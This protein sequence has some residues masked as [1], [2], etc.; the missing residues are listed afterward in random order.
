MQI[1]TAANMGFTEEN[2]RHGSPAAGPQHHGF[3]GSRI[4]IDGDLREIE[5][6]RMQQRLGA[7]AIGAGRRRV[8]DNINRL[9]FS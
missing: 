1:V 6:A 4:A 2:L 9:R 8:N 3:A 7:A 5:A